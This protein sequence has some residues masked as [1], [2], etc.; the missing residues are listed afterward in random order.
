MPPLAPGFGLFRPRMLVSGINCS[1]ADCLRVV[2]GAEGTVRRMEAFR[3]AISALRLEV[4]NFEGALWEGLEERE[5]DLD[6]DSGSFS[7][8]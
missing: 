2:S 1:R 5:G 6:G 4:V 7:G 8:S 3:A